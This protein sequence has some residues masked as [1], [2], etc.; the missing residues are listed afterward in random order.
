MTDMD[1]VEDARALVGE[2]FPDAVAA[3]LG[4]G[5]L[6]PRR[7]A[8]S[9]LDIVI[10]VAGPPAPY[11]ESLRWRGWPV[12]TFVHDAA[13][14]EHFFGQDAARR[15][16][17]LARMCSDGVILAG[18]HDVTDTIRERAR[19]VIAAGPPPLSRPELDWARYGL[20]DTLDDLAGSNDQAEIAVIGWHVWMQ[21]AEL[22]L[23]LAGH[24]SGSGKW[25]LRELR[26]ADPELAARM[27]A[28][29]GNPA[30]LTSAADE[31]LARAGGRLWDGLKLTSTGN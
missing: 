15:R 16:P 25:L 1:P 23:A 2:R 4:G 27:V 24:W 26:D 22:A 29:L 10:I 28:A 11:R 21:T 8:T 12:E 7:T 3:F 31:V 17:S 13:S 18:S 9:D 19:F 5:V 6:S 20:T 30:A 14:L